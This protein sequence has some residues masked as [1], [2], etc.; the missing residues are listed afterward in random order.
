MEERCPAGPGAASRGYLPDLGMKAGGGMAAPT[1][2]AAFACREPEGTHRK[3][4]HGQ[5]FTARSC[6]GPLV[7]S[8]LPPSLLPAAPINRNSP[9]SKA[10]KHKQVTTELRDVGRRQRQTLRSGLGGLGRA[11]PQ[12]GPTG[13]QGTG[14]N[15]LQVARHWGGKGRAR[16][17]WIAGIW[18]WEPSQQLDKALWTGTGQG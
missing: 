5:V 8:L 2:Q 6:S 15:G 16:T 17:A 9:Q 14:K 7:S 12:R 13:R 10:G 11:G 4:A 3:T 18:D 1:A